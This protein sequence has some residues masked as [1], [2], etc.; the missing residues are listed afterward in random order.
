MNIFLP[1][2]RE[3]HFVP[4]M[5][6][7]WYTIAYFVPFGVIK[8]RAT[9]MIL[10]EIVTILTLKLV[11]E[12]YILW[13]HLRYFSLT[14]IKVFI[15]YFLSVRNFANKF[16]SS[17]SGSLLGIEFFIIFFA[18]LNIS[19]GFPEYF[20]LLSSV[21]NSNI[22]LFCIFCFSITLKKVLW[23][24]SLSDSYLMKFSTF[25]LFVF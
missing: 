17:S 13:F 23:H 14:K 1:S 18:D 8:N 3:S 24:F 11:S 12:L 15:I 6:F 22:V 4:D 7:F 21:Y 25:C 2:Q 9:K 20:D 10:M 5:D 19:L 16:S